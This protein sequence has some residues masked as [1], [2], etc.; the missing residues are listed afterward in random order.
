MAISTAAERTEGFR[1]AMGAAGLPVAEGYLR[2]GEF[3]LNG[4]YRCALEMMKLT[5]RPTAL[6]STNYE[7]TLGSLRALREIGINCPEEVS[8]VGFDDMVMGS[9]G[10]SLATMFSPQPTTVAQ[11][12]HS[13]G[14]EA[15]NLLIRR[16]E[17]ADGTA[18]RGEDGILRLPVELRVRESTAPPS[19]DPL[20]G[21]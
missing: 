17:S 15:V 12:G 21:H 7:M 8:L 9:D 18:P 14:R 19:D 16:I 1:Q 3:T 11:A 13:I 5:P 6:F 2:S 20:G 10:F 4:G